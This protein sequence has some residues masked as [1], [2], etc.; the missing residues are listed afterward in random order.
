MRKLD[1]SAIYGLIA[2]TYTPLCLAALDAATSRRL[3]LMVWTGAFAGIADSLLS[4]GGMSSKARSALIYVLLGWVAVFYWADIRQILGSN[5]SALLFAGG[6]TYSLGA[7]V[8]ATRF[9]DPAP[10]TFGYHEVFHALVI[11]ASIFHFIAVRLV[12]RRM[13][14][15]AG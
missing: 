6:V 14:S 2:G 1:H 15:L 10:Q 4:G 8:Y 7:V 3:L 9:P 11:L 12:V 5:G 13:A